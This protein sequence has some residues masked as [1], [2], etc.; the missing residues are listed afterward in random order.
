[1]SSKTIG[2]VNQAEKGVRQSSEEQNDLPSHSLREEF[3]DLKQQLKNALRKIEELRLEKK[4]MKREIRNLSSSAL[5]QEFLLKTTKF[6]DRLLKEMK[7]RDAKMYVP[8]VSHTEKY[9]LESKS[10]STDLGQMRSTGGENQ[11]V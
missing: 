9:E 4:E 6:T 5:E 2:E 1:M 11:S 3:W 7:E 8:G 10:K